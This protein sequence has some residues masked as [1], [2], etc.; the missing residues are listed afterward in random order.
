M[1]IIMD[2]VQPIQ[3]TYNTQPIDTVSSEQLA[4]FE[5]QDM[6]V[7]A[8]GTIES[9]KEDLKNAK[10]MYDSVF[11]LNDLYMEEKDKVKEATERLK[12]EKQQIERRPEVMSLAEKVK[13]IKNEIK[14]KKDS[15]SIYALEVFRQTG[16]TEF[17]RDGQLYQIKTVAN[18]VKK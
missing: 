6:A 8:T 7:R 4:L 17:E 12:A 9:L 13:E 10:E 5:L 1:K 18:I 15:I 3:Q 2:N 16:N 14:E 11:K